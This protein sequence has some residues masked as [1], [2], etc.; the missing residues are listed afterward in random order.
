[1]RGGY[2]DEAAPSID[3]KNHLTRPSEALPCMPLKKACGAKR[4]LA[5]NPMRI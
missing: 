1:M 2:M 3:K 5:S 4:S